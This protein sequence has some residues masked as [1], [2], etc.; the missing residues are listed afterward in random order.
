[1]N[2]LGEREV[3]PLLSRNGL[4]LFGVARLLAKQ[5]AYGYLFSAPETCHL[6]P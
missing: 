5:V 1:L 4:G 6:F 2:F 3:L